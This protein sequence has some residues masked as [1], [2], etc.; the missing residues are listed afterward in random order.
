MV[1]QAG[2]APRHI[3]TPGLRQD[4]LL[5]S[6]P[7][8]L[9]EAVERL[10]IAEAKVAALQTPLLP[11]KTAAHRLGISLSTARRWAKSKHGIGVR[12]GG[13]LLIDMSRV[14]RPGAAP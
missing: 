12:R 4:H 11:L 14:D 7:T 8:T 13:R 5:A 6:P 9:A 2:S 3:A 10:A 1:S